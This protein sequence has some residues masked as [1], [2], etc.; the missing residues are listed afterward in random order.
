ML[1][2]RRISEWESLLPNPP[3]VRIDRSLLINL[4]LIQAVEVK[5]RDET[6]VSLD[7]L[8]HPL[9]IGRL[10]SARL[11]SLLKKPAGR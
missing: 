8:P 11:R 5:H 6:R 10:A 7:G 4:D 2:L 9:L 1:I 3:F